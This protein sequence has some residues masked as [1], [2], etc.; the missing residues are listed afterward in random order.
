MEKTLFYIDETPFLEFEQA[1]TKVGNEVDRVLKGTETIK[2][3][4]LSLSSIR[5]FL[6]S[7]A[8]CFLRKLVIIVCGNIPNSKE[9]AEALGADLLIYNDNDS[10]GYHL[11]KKKRQLTLKD[12]RIICRT[13]GSISKPKYVIWSNKGLQYQAEMTA[14]RLKYSTKDRLAVAIPPSS[15][16]GL[17]ILNI[18]LRKN[19]PAVFTSNTS[20]KSIIDLLK[21]IDATSFDS[22]PQVYSL[23][24]K[25]IESGQIDVSTLPK[26]RLW[27]CGGDV[28]S[29]TVAQKWLEV[30]GKPL[31]DGYGLSEAGPNVALNGPDEY[32]LG[33]VGKPLEG[34][35][36]KISAD[37]EILVKGPGISLGYLDEDNTALF[38]EA[39]WLK[40]GDIGEM[41]S[42]GYLKIIG[43]KKN[44]IIINGLNIIPEQIENVINKHPQVKS[45]S[46]IGLEKNERHEI[47]LAVLV[48]TD[49]LA[50]NNSFLKKSIREH[51]KKFLKTE[52]IPKRIFFSKELPCLA[53]GKVDRKI[54]MELIY[55]QLTFCNRKK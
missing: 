10:I 16:Y 55:E 25:Y 33:T 2:Y 26:M 36:I 8:A 7:F 24:L 14:K 39:G 48:A 38:D 4:A 43:R 42:E 3:V 23:L 5:D 21:K 22:V 45:C 51:C 19:I 46:V 17:S 52:Q 1:V 35:E 40:T 53:N 34:T 32:R 44:I 50:K 49:A 30:M 18:C 15:A 9:E 11:L 12:V 6:V 37:K 54:V 27:C 20:P 47:K 29:P 31:L 28:L 41:D 13:S